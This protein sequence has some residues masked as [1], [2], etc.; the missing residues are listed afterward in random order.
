MERLVIFAALA[1]LLGGVVNGR[2]DEIALDLANEQSADLRKS[3]DSRDA[4]A[5]TP[6]MILVAAG[7]SYRA[8]MFT[9]SDSFDGD[10]EVL[11]NLGINMGPSR[12]LIPAGGSVIGG[13]A[14]SEPFETDRG[15][16]K[17]VF[18]ASSFLDRAETANAEDLFRANSANLG[19]AQVLQPARIVGDRSVND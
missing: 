5:Q 9:A 10:R 17:D 6:S 12:G 19:P 7:L 18:I 3:L 13:A 16:P 15:L 14:F 1:L 4:T 11:E 2:A 8:H